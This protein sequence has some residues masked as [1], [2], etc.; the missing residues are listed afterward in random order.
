M[1][2]N[3]HIKQSSWGTIDYN[4]QFEKLQSDSDRKPNESYQN[5]ADRQAEHIGNTDDVRKFN[6]SLKK[7]QKENTKGGKKK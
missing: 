1:D 2:N 7:F 5:Y 6:E 4:K 3:D